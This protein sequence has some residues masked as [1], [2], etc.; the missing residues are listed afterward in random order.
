MINVKRY[1]FWSTKNVQN[2]SEQALTEGILNYG[3][4]DDFKAL[5]K[6][7]GTVR[8]KSIFQSLINKR[9]VNLRPQTVNFFKNYFEKYA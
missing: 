2:L 5:E 6:E 8:L 7:F 4:W 1:L 3:N 9:R